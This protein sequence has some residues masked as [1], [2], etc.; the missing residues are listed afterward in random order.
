[1]EDQ[2]VSPR[3]RRRFLTVLLGGVGAVLAVMGGWPV[4]RFLSP[5]STSGA[6]GQVKIAKSPY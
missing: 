5:R 6:G 4:L 2:S 1:M 3:Q